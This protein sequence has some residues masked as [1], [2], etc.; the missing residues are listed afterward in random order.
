[1]SV[2][3]GINYLGAL[4]PMGGAFARNGQTPGLTAGIAT[5]VIPLIIVGVELYK[6]IDG[7]E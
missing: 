5:T 2:R 7:C 1:M 6:S 4:G 3:S